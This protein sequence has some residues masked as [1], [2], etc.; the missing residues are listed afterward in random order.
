MGLILSCC[1]MRG[2]IGAVAIARNGLRA[3][4]DK[5]SNSY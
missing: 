1:F 5:S 4:R 2:Q 3:S